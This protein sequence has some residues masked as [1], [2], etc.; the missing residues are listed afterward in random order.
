[1]KK[2]APGVYIIICVPATKG[3][4]GSASN[5][6]KRWYMHRRQ[7]AD[8]IHPNKYLQAAYNKYGA[9]QFEWQVLE[10]TEDRIAREQYWMDLLNTADRRYGY[11]HCTVAGSTSGHTGKP[12]TLETRTKQSESNK[13]KHGGVPEEIKEAIRKRRS[14][15]AKYR[16]LEEEFHLCQPVIYRA[17]H[18]K[19][20]SRLQPPGRR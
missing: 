8:G 16:E 17:T 6:S 13:G 20:R 19:T 4:V 5:I 18:S 1:M 11:N 9:D 14:E 2:D 3:Y 7:L 10:N 15:G 12:A